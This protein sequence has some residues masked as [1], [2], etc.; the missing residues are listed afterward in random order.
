MSVINYIC[1]Q[2]HLRSQFSWETKTG[3]TSLDST[4]CSRSGGQLSQKKSSSC[5]EKFSACARIS[6]FRFAFFLIKGKISPLFTSVAVTKSAKVAATMLVSPV[7][8]ASS[9]TFLP[10][11]NFGFESKKSESRRAP[12]H[13]CKCVE[14]LRIFDLPDGHLEPDKVNTAACAMR[15]CN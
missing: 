12:R 6:L 2:H 5:T 10:C 9:R 8:D 1:S 15:Y 4:L 3:T 14:L 7:P 13:T 11:N